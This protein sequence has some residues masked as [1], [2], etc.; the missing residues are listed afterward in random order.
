MP[1]A[2]EDWQRTD[3]D[4]VAYRPESP[5]DPDAR[6]EAFLVVPTPADTFVGVWTQGAIGDESNQRVVAA[7]STDCGETWS[8]PVVVAGPGEDES[9]GIASWGIPLVAPD[10]QPDGGHRIYCFYNKNVGTVDGRVDTTGRLRYRYSDDDGRTWSDTAHEF[11]IAPA[12]FSHPDSS[13]PPNWV[14]YQP[15]VETS[16]G[17]ALLGFMH[18]ASETYYPDHEGR[19]RR[20]LGVSTLFNTHSEVRF[21]RFENVFTATDPEDLRATTWPNDQHG[22]QV[23]HP[24]RPGASFAQEPAIQPLSDGRLICLMRTLTGSVYFALSDDHGRS[25]D[26]PRPLCYDPFDIQRP[27]QNPVAPAP[28]YRLPDGR[29]FVVFYNND[30]TASGAT[31]AE[32]MQRTRRPA[33]YAIG[34]EVDHP[35]HPLQFDTPKIL[36][37]NDGSPIGS[38]ERTEVATHPSFFVHKDTAYFWY[39]DRK[40]FL[41]GKDLTDVLGL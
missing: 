32:D 16:D 39:P 34:E 4:Y 18:W 3:P 25:W 9:D 40:H 1:N 7:R 23:P 26:T 27:L 2:S 19:E 15:P 5:M 33:W 38:V 36:M 24:D 11:E 22:L 41:L 29:Y 21:L 28:I 20:S 35:T 30:G 12:A 17:A 14:A 37:D 8:D 31:G 10:T 6:N 13:V